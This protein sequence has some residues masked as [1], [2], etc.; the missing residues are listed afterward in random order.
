[1]SAPFPLEKIRNIGIM[2]HIDAG[3]TTATERILFY[4]G[5]TH[6]MGE[7]D[8]GEAKMDWMELEKERGISITAAATFCS[9]QG[10]QIN[11]IDTPGHVDFTAEVE[12]SLR[13][14]DAAIGIFCA[15]AGVQPQSETV[16]KQADRYRI[17]RLVFINKMDRVG[18]RFEEVVREM[19][20]R[21]SANAVPVQM[22]IGEESDFVGVVDLV[23]MKARLWDQDPLG[24]S[25]RE[26]EIPP[27][28]EL[29][30]RLARRCLL[31][32]LAE[33]DDRILEEYLA[34][35]DIPQSRLMG[36]VR[37]AT[38]AGRMF[39][40]L[41]GAAF[42]NKGIQ[43]LLDAVVDYLPSPEEVPPA[44]A[45][46]LGSGERIWRRPDPEEP[47]AALVF[48]VM[49]DQF[50]G[51]LAFLR[52]YS[53]RIAVGASVYNATTGRRE[54]IHRLLRMHANDREQIEEVRAGDIAVAVGLK[55][56][57]TGDTLCAETEAI[58]LEAI[59]FPQPVASVSIEPRTQAESGR[60]NEA[61]GRLMEEDQTFRMRQ[62]PDTG[63]TIISGMGELH[64]EIL[65]ERLARE[66]GV[67]ARVGKPE[68]AY[69]ETIT[70]SADAEGRF[71]R[72]S[73]LRGQYG[74]VLM[75]F[76][77]LA[78]GSGFLFENRLDGGA[79]PREYIPAVEKGVREAMDNGVLAGY[80][81]VDFRAILLDGSH[82][83]VDS[84]ELA[85]RIAASMAYKQAMEA[86]GP[87]ILEPLMSLE[88][89][90]PD[91]YLGALVSDVIARTGRVEG[92]EDRPDGKVIR[93]LAPLRCLFGYANRLRSLAQGRATHAMQ[94]SAYQPVPRA[95]QDEIVSKNRI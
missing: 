36:A 75:R 50:T 32:K 7:V 45:V 79:V 41:C 95:V 31:E 14:M 40:V 21:L 49:G 82:H 2:A 52:V 53:G 86:A 65:V 18:A 72:Q 37:T 11:I 19:R 88:V 26:T 66:H 68:V 91:E 43:P 16:W 64:L 13:V 42:R 12:R 83:E 47:F 67:R 56:V 46:R 23:R 59:V 33:L 30:A 22:P 93:A 60:L 5:R 54:R 6:K 71:V 35:G 58:L 87:V 29:R 81:A 63:Q 25:F 9:W 51:R 15:V 4:T 85:F 89:V 38:L 10:C 80:P 8:E 34:T 78:P 57:S 1:M 55:L 73:G 17:P 94:F 69:R 92:I 3:K 44:A 76:E 39:P 27:A 20:L 28:L 90:T 62:D 48:K 24:S 84:S 61:L 70:A 74:H 77:P